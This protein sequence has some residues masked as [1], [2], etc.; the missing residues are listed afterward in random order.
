MTAIRSMSLTSPMPDEAPVMRTT[1]PVMSSFKKG[2]TNA[3][4]SSLH[5]SEMGRY[6][7][8]NAATKTCITTLREP[9]NSSMDDGCKMKRA[10]KRCRVSKAGNIAVLGQV[11]LHG[12][13]NSFTS[14]EQLVFK[15]MSAAPDHLSL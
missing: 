9:F 4:L 7:R 5:T 1:F 8:R 2:L 13:W 15:E 12:W 11:T 3:H 6:T 10:G 14:L